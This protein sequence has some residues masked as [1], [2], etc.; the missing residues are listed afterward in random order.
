MPR[1]SRSKAAA[2]GAPA[3]KRQKAEVDSEVSDGSFPTV[4]LIGMRGAGK[5]HLGRAAAAA[6]SATF[7]DMDEAYE[8]VHGK[9]MDT[10]KAEGWPIFREREVAMLHDTLASKARGHVVACGGGVVETEA[11][12]E[13]LRAHWPVVQA[14]KPIDEIESYLGV[15][16]TRPSLGEPPRAVYERRKALYNECADLDHLACPGEADFKQSE[17]RL[18]ATLERVLGIAPPA[19]MPHE[20]S[21]FLSLTYPDLAAVL[22]LPAALWTNTDA[23]E[24]RCDLLHSLAPEDVQRQIA[25]LSANCPLPI[26][27]TIR[28][29]TE[30]GAFTGTQE[31]YLKLNELAMRA[32]CPWIDF[33]AGRSSAALLALADEAGTTLKCRLIG[34]NHVLGPMPSR[35]EVGKALKRCELGGRA[36]LAKFVGVAREPRDALHVHAAAEAANLSVPHIALAM[37][38]PGQMSRVLNVLYT[39]VNHPLLPAAAAPGQMPASQ[40]LA[41]RK[42]YGYL[43]VRT[44]SIFGN[45]TKFSPSP[46]MHNAAFAANGCAHT[47][48]VCETEDVAAVLAELA[49]PNAGGGSVTIP[50]KEKLMGH[51]AELSPSAKAIGSL[52][53]LTVRPDGTLAADNTD[54]IGIRNLLRDN[55]AAQG[56]STSPA[57]LVA[58]VM[59]GGG[60]ARAACYALQQMHIG[61]VHVYNRST[62]KA[63][64][65][66]DEFGGTLMPELS[67]GAAALSRLDLLVS[68]VPG[69]AG[70][71]LSHELLSAKR[72]IVLDA[73][74]R[75]RETPLLAAAAAAGCV[76][77]EGIEM[78]FEQ[79]CA[80]AEI[81]THRPAPRAA[82]AEGLAAFTGSQDFGPLPARLEAARLG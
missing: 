23:V 65:L 16:A 61:S 74:Y 36:D 21:F 34:S 51:V 73:A 31:Q 42:A 9:I 3:A 41:A 57:E 54:W 68:C 18:V 6:L 67:E 17:K 63:Q 25:L 35:T 40:I 49:K 76:A 7:I 48:G 47:Y 66:A 52:N 24:L 70:L 1:S 14:V 58:I 78:L 79:G 29:K 12:R 46:A 11:G 77:I 32:G 28:S 53:T 64:A 15:D 59:G 60:T 80:Q 43:P 82:I 75:P 13:L 4:V 2:A 33:E 19:A 45:P 81:W 44:W 55:L 26:I 62:D 37:G 10:V 30:G 38:A 50:L 20:H 69:S 27:F 22:P 8:A 71:T 5:S 72:P 39:P 56:G